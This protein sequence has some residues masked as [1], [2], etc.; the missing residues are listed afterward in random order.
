MRERKNGEVDSASAESG[1]AAKS[2][3]KPE[4]KEKKKEEITPRFLV[5]SSP[6]MHE[7]QTVS[8][9]MKLVIYALLPVT[10]FSIFMFGLA[11]FRVI[12]ISVGS[13]LLFEALSQR[14]MKRPVSLRDYSA[15]L[16]GLLLALNL[17]PTSPWWMILVGTFFAIVIGKQIYGGLGYNPFNP[18]L[19]GRVVLTISFPVQ[20]TARWI[21]P[22][23]WGMNPVTTATPLGRIREALLSGGQVDLHLSRQGF[24][25][26]L[27]GNRAGS[28]GEVSVILLLAG[29]L[30]LIAKRVITWHTPVS[31]IAT[32]WVLTGI[33]H[34][35]DPTRYANP[36]FH[37]VTGGLFIGALFMATDYVTSPISGRGM[38][39]FGAGCGL[40][41][42]VIR[43]FGSYPEGVSFAI[44]LMNGITPLIDRYTKPKVFG[45]RREEKAAA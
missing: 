8:G 34:L 10:A 3:S 38:L 19:V 33:F 45:I 15:V 24:L 36:S 39:I 14:V 37:V 28:L 6:H 12:L 25:D 13:A 17:P 41:T 11:A 1:G 23:M 18:A 42:V 44:L 22:S 27:L 29:G 5:S 9:I 20:M 43:L 32:V 30:F 26:L 2:V 4:K 16:T 35:I 40:F 21:T 7:G 31:F